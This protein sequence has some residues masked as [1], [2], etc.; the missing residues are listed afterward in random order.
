MNDIKIGDIVISTFNIGTITGRTY[1]VLGIEL[2]RH[3]DDVW[4]KLKHL[5]T[6]EIITR[7][8]RW[9]RLAEIEEMI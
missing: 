8:H 5:D 4:Y 9:Y 3:D 6:G 1:R 2:G 7:N